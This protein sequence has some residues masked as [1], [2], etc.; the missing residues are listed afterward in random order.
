MVRTANQLK[1]LIVDDEIAHM[2]ALCHTLKDNGYQIGGL[3]FAHR[4]PRR[5]AKK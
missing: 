3:F 2:R 4:R 5:T 1:I